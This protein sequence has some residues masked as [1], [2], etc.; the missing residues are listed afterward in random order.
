MTITQLEYFIEIVNT[1]HFSQ[2]AENLFISQSTLSYGIKELEKELGTSLFTRHANKRISLTESGQKFLHYAEQALNTLEE[3][4]KELR[5]MNDPL[6]GTI[7]IGVFFSTA[8]TVLP[9][10][11]NEFTSVYPQHNIRFRFEVNHHWVDMNEL[12]S[13]GVYDFCISVT[14]DGR[15]MHS[16]LAGHQRIIAIVP[17]KHP[18]AYRNKLSASDLKDEQIVAIDPKSNLDHFIYD[19]YRRS[20]LEPDMTYVSDWTA[21]IVTASLENRI[22]ISSDYPVDE[23]LFRKIPLD[24]DNDTLPLYLNWSMNRELSPSAALFAEFFTS[25]QLSSI[26]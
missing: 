8:L 26:Y 16:I 10:L 13:K 4:K 21:Q 19:F 18:L 11:I 9:Y 25:R 17:A 20:H 3:G 12:I 14:H 15:N 7:R 24:T 6:C 1:G 22:A 23:R 2:A 5:I